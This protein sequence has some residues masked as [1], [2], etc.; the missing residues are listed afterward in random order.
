MYVSINVRQKRYFAGQKLNIDY[1]I[2]NDYH[3]KFNSCNIVFRIGKNTIVE[4]P[5]KNIP[6]NSITFYKQESNEIKLLAKI[7]T[8][9]YKVDVELI[10]NKNIISKN[11]FEIVK[12]K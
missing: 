6:G 5:V 8:G 2:I 7:K 1:W 11:D 4:L 3:K 9:K 12:E 10:Q